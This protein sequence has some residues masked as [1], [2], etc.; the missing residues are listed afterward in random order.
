MGTNN[1]WD[2]TVCG[3]DCNTVHCE[4]EQCRDHNMEVFRRRINAHAGDPELAVYGR[5]RESSQSSVS[6]RVAVGLHRIDDWFDE[7][8]SSRNG[9]VS[10]WVINF[11]LF[12][13]LVAILLYLA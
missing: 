1:M 7:V 6:R 13:V 2:Y 11:V 3:S 9:Q 10:L 4:N 8:L 12:S 5:P